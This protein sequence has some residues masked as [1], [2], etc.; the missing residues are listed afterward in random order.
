MPGHRC[1]PSPKAFIAAEVHGEESIAIEFRPRALPSH[2]VVE[3]V[4]RATEPLSDAGAMMRE[5][6]R[7]ADAARACVLMAHRRG[8]GFQTSSFGTRRLSRVPCRRLG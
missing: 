5:V 7:R 3:V 6:D 4:A 8:H 2:R 1:H